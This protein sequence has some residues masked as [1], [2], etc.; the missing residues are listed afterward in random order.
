MYDT[1]GHSDLH[2]R[3]I[4][5]WWVLGARNTGAIEVGETCGCCAGFDEREK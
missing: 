2:I 1:V 5:K 4:Q 3:V